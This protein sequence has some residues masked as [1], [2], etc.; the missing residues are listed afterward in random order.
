MNVVAFESYYSPY[1]TNG[2][3][4]KAT[5]NK[6][7][8]SIVYIEGSWV[9]LSKHIYCISFCEVIFFIANSADSVGMPLSIFFNI[10]QLIT[11]VGISGLQMVNR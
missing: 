8:Q 6:S 5:Y 4:H 7:G 3:F 1:Q 9:I 2:I 10:C 11:R